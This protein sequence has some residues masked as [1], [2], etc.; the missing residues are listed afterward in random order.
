MICPYSD[1]T[2]E[3]QYGKIIQSDTFSTASPLTIVQR[4][5]F[6]AKYKF[7]KVRSSNSSFTR[8][9]SLD[10]GRTA[11]PPWAIRKMPS[12]V[13]VLDCDMTAHLGCRLQGDQALFPRIDIYTVR[14]DSKLWGGL[15]YVLG[16]GYCCNRVRQIDS[17]ISNCRNSC[18]GMLQVAENTS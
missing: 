1:H 10:F 12:C 2:S 5:S 11:L 7:V 14:Y 4:Q 9:C 3:K 13:A 16:Q 17:C 8:I 6:A 15:G 18:I